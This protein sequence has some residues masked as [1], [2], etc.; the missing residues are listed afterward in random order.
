LTASSKASDA[1]TS[2][3]IVSVEMRM[4]RGLLPQFQHAR[5]H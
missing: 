2:R 5:P 1:T 4:S 3:A